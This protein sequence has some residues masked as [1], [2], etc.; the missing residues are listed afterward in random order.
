M[1]IKNV[2]SSL[3]DISKSLHSVNAA[4]EYLIKNTR[5]VVILCS[6]SIIAAHKGDL[7]LAK[8]KI[9][10]AELV[11]KKNQKKA[12]DDFKKYLITPEQE[13]VEACSF[14][15][16][17]ENKE[18]P[19]LKSMKVSKESY[20]LGLLDCIGELKRL[21]LDNI[22]KDKLKEAN[23]IFN[24]MEN[25]YL[26]LYPFAMF[27]KIVKEAR[28]KLDVNR[29]LVEESRAIITEEIRRNHFVK[30]ITEKEK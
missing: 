20:I 25:L 21:M 8:Q 10:N 29:S 24:V 4:R 30:A 22:R 13:L 11:L 12:K 19:S 1:A 9:K 15:A 14:L 2:K 16:V 23:R 26:I 18:I 7:R 5:D 28:R 6:H 17:I 3:N 27:D